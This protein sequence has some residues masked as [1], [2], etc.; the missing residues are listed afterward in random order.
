MFPTIEL[1]REYML[2]VAAPA[3][4]SGYADQYLAHLQDEGLTPMLRQPRGRAGL[5]RRGRGGRSGP[6]DR[7]RRGATN[8]GPGAASTSGSPVRSMAPLVVLLATRAM[9]GVARIVAAGPGGPVSEQVYLGSVVTLPLGDG[10]AGEP[11]QV[12]MTVTDAQDSVEGFL[13]IRSLVVLRE[14]DLTAQVVAHKSAADALRQELDFVMGTR[15]WKVT[16][17]LRKW[18]GRGA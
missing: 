3:P 11:A 5:R 18:K 13:G 12:T 7:R 1:G 15:S 14:D 17:P 10:R 2:A 8:C 9:P 16:A 6:S 4:D